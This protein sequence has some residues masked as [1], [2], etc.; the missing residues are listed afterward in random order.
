MRTGDFK[1]L[2]KLKSNDT[3]VLMG[4]GS[5]INDLTAEQWKKIINY[6]FWA[7]NNYVYMPLKPPGCDFRVIPKF[8]HIELKSYDREIVREHF[9]KKW[10]YYKDTNFIMSSNRFKFVREGIGHHDES[11][12]FTYGYEERGK[13]EKKLGGI[14]DANYNVSSPILTKS[15]DASL[16]VLIDML[17]KLDYKKVILV[18]IDMRDSR[19]FWTDH[20]EFGPVHHQFNKQHE[21][22]KTADQPHNTY[23]IKDFIIDFN[24]RYFVPNNKEI[25]LIST[26][27]LLYPSLRMVEL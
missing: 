3:V 4:S 9:D 15:Y 6:D 8:Y 25:V 10:K 13:K 7:M 27:T 12:I 22:G 1:D 5:S 14:M 26:K 20:P 19:Y 2:S 23:H 24:N 16:T 11:R 21:V 17:Y 18:G